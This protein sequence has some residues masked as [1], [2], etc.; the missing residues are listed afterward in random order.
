MTDRDYH[1]ASRPLFQEY[2]LSS[3]GHECKSALVSRA[4]ILK[5]FSEVGDGP[6]AGMPKGLGGAPERAIAGPVRTK[7]FE[8]RQRD[9]LP[10]EQ[11]FDAICRV[12]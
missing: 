11:M 10:R 7:P 9:G 2:F 5:S 3:D 8:Y 1:I 12:A 4:D 6:R